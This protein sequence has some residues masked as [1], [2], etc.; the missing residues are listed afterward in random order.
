MEDLTGQ[1]I[2][3]YELGERIGAG[4]FGVIYVARQSTV[5]REVAIKIILPGFANQ[6]EFIR[7]FETE[8]Q[9]IARLE[10]PHIVPLHDYWRDPSGAYIVMRYLREGSLRDALKK[11]P[12]DPE[13]TARLLDQITSA[14]ALAHRNDVIHRDLKPANIL[15]DEDGNAY[16]ADFG[17][18]KF[19]GD[20]SGDLTKGGVIGS[21]DYISPEQACSEPVTPRTDIYSLGVVLFELLTAQHPFPDASS[22][23]RLFKHLNDPLPI[24]TSLGE[25]GIQSEIN[26]V[27]QKATAKKPTDRFGDVLELAAAFR[28][29][30]GIGAPSLGED[31]VEMLTL[32]EQEV[33]RYIVEG[34]SNREIANQLVI[35][36]STVK[37]YVNQIYR[38]LGV[39]SRVQA[40]VRARELNLVIPPSTADEHPAITESV[41]SVSMPAP[42]NPY[43]GLRPFQAVDHRY[44][45]GREKLVDRLIQRLDERDAE[46]THRFLAVVGPSG[47]GKSSLVKAGLIPSLWRGDLP[48]SERWYV[49]DMLP[50]AH[51]LD[52]LEIALLQVAADQAAN[53]RA[54]L[55]RDVRGLQ[56]VAQ[57]ILP[58][59]DCELVVIVDQ[60]EEVFTLVE[61]EA[62]RVH[63]LDLLYTAVTDP[64]SRVRVIVTLR[65]DFYDRPLHYPDFGELVHSR[66]ETVLPLSADE[67]ERVIRRPAELV[68]VTY[69]EGLVP[70]ITDEVLYQPGA[71]PL[72][73]YALTELFDHRQGRLLTQ[74]AY[75]KMGGTIGALA[76]RADDIFEHLSPDGQ[77]LA[78]HM[79]LRLV[80]LG[81]GVEDTRRRVSRA[82]LMALAGATEDGGRVMGDSAPVFGLPSSVDLMEDVIDTFT[83]YRLLSLDHDPGTRA[84]TVEV[85]HEAI[86]REWELLRGW[87][88][89]SRSDIRNQQ[90]LARAAND[91]LVADRDLSFLLHGTRLY[92]FENWANETD[93]ALTLDEQK[94]I[95]T[96]LAAK[97]IRDAEEIERQG[98]EIQLERRSR[99]T[100]RAMVGVFACAAILAIVLSVYAFSQRRD[101]LEA[102]SLSLAANAQ[103]ALHDGDTA[104]GLV[105]ALAANQIKDSPSAVQRT[106]L[107]AAYAPGARRQFHISEIASDIVAMPT[108]LDIHPDGRTVITGLDDGTILLWDLE[109]GEEI[110]RLKGHTAGVNDVT[111]S[112]DGTTAISGGEDAVAILWDTATWSEI[113]RLRG[114]SGA[115]RSVAFSPDGRRVVSGGLSSEQ[116]NDPGELI[117]WDLETG[118]ELNCFDGEFQ[119][120]VDLA[121]SQD[122]D[123]VL[124]STGETDYAG[125]PGQ[126]YSI[127]LWNTKTGQV[128]Q[129]FDGFL[130][131]NPAV[132]I[133]PDS[134][135]AA[136]GS[137]DHNIYLF[138]TSSGEI[139]DTLEGHTSGISSMVF[140]PNGQLILS[141]SAR[142]SLRL[143]DLNSGKQIVHF[144]IHSG[145]VTGIDFTPDGR[146]AISSDSEGKIMLW[147]LFNASELQRFEGHLAPV[148]D[149]DFTPD[150]RYILSASGLPDPGAEPIQEESLRI[151]DVETGKQTHSLDHSLS[152]IFQIAI[153][154]DGRQALT[155]HLIDATTRLWDL[156]SGH[157]IRAFQ[158]HQT[159]VFNVAFAPGG[160]RGLSGSFDEILVW[161]LETGELLQR[162][163]EHDGPIWALSVSHDGKMVL[164]GADDLY[165]RLW[166][167][168]TGSEIHRFKGPESG[169]TDVAF[170]PDGQKA[171]SGD[172]QGILIVWDL[173]TGEQIHQW[174]AHGKI[175]IVDRIRVAISSDGRMAVSSGWDGSVALWDLETYEEI[176]R[177]YGHPSDFIFDVAF[178]PDGRSV[179]SAGVDGLII[180]WQLPI[181]S[182][183][184]LLEW[185]TANRQLR[186][187]SCEE[188]ELYRIEPFCE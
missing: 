160:K 111:F 82:E 62:A 142:G 18:A 109:T 133:H 179:I 165:L 162:F 167:L 30:I 4:G 54:Q 95:N 78:R 38:K 161:D 148:L 65:A 29:A 184:E 44:F 178:S 125:L 124:A 25:N 171:I 23:E 138:D 36:L 91:W 70:I 154:P 146:S 34:L 145:Q 42:E 22:V 35:T 188:R 113:T 159:P 88:D 66:M 173:E 107:D 110:R 157:E 143:W 52:E 13:S 48:G 3:G 79:F 51:P 81:E 181:M 115:I 93:L 114:H 69:E 9:L 77:A 61:D 16:L 2:K 32:R 67:L 172:S 53:L 121:F 182:Q 60:F 102:Y 122:N 150:G 185:I 112:P 177:Y 56:R 59:D 119:V 63:F 140:S 89:E 100:L 28:E 85:A 141:G 176:F 144:A 41:T 84:P 163:S 58:K 37:W 83:N 153:S 47:S 137:S 98:R 147:D 11:E 123:M 43:R 118:G 187:F 8:A 74:S 5:G 45:F 50:G 27:I 156:E 104:T 117:L 175:G 33:L 94:Y 14:L 75:Q 128:L 180:Q 19:L 31:I 152:D 12:F 71:L 72:L 168:E 174:A 127:M 39:R 169:F 166:D 57:L 101:A 86:L 1:V 20:I 49:V 151:W 92:Q 129:H 126:V 136:F 149:A 24:I 97:K 76:T 106:L 158:G 64:R 186:E 103:N 135:T 155:A 68:G 105:L 130:Q 183:D 99:S 139:I 131:D 46:L 87:L 7:R 6:P 73:Q 21:L 15:L 80:T 116:T 90:A 134:A 17:I 120:V 108:S 55:D 132:A 26:A 164:S 170:Y 96:S 10:H 40:I